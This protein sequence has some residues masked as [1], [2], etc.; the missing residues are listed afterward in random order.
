M[1]SV[2]FT[3]TS[4]TPTDEAVSRR[5]SPGRSYTRHD[6]DGGAPRLEQRSVGF[7]ASIV[8]GQVLTREAQATDARPGRL[9]RRPVPAAG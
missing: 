6:L 3:S 1:A 2:P 8:N 9:L 5:L 7:A 4:S